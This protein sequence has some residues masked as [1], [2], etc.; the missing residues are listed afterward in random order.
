MCIM[1]LD[2]FDFFIY[3]L[4]EQFCLFGV[5]VW[6]MCNDMLLLMI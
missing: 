2:N 5:E 1:L 4:V 6:V 3:N